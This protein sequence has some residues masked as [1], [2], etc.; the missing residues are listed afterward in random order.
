MELN[1]YMIIIT[2]LCIGITFLFSIILI[3]DELYNIGYFT[4]NY[5]YFYNYGTFMSKFN[6]VQTIECETNRFNVYN[7]ID[8]LYK[9]IFNKSYFNYLITIVIILITILFSLAYGVYFY[10]KFI[11]EVPELC[12]F[13]MET[14]LSLPKQILKCLC[15][16][17]HKIIP[18][19]TS[20]YLIVF[21]LLIII[22]LSY[23]FKTFVSINITPTTDNY[24]LSF[25][26]L[27][28]FVLLLFYYSFSLYNRKTDDK[29]KDLIIYF[30][31]TI[32]FISSPYIYN[33]IISNYN[34]NI[35]L[36]TSK[37]ISTMYD[38]Y[39]Q[40]PPI[41]PTPIQKPTHNRKDLLTLFKYDDKNTDPEYKIQK[42]IV[43]DYYKAIK[44]Y[45]NE[46][47]HYNERYNAYTSSSLTSTVFGDKADYLDIAINILGFNNK[48]HIYII[49]LVIIAYII[50]NMYTDDVSYVCFIYLLTILITITI[51]NSIL[52]YN[53]YL[54]K[55]IIYEPLAH[56]K[57]DITNANTALN[58]ELDAQ[59]GIGFYNKL[60]NNINTTSDINESSKNAKQIFAEIKTL[61]T[62]KNY[63]LDNVKKI[64]GYIND[65][66]QNE[67]INISSDNNIHKIDNINFYYK[68][69]SGVF[70]DNEKSI[71][72][73]LDNC[74]SSINTVSKNDIKIEPNK[75][76]IFNFNGSNINI[77]LKMTGYYRYVLYRIYQYKKL[78]D[79]FN[80]VFTSYVNTNHLQEY[81]KYFDELTTLYNSLDY[82]KESTNNN[83]SIIIQTINGN[84]DRLISLS[85]A[86]TD[87]KR[88][89]MY[90]DLIKQ[91]DGFKN[92]YI[93]DKINIDTLK[94]SYFID[95]KPVYF[96][97]EHYKITNDLIVINDTSFIQ[98]GVVDYNINDI[99]N[100]PKI[101][102]DINTSSTYNKLP[103][104][105]LDSNNNELYISISL[106]NNIDIYINYNIEPNEDINKYRLT[107]ENTPPEP[108][109]PEEKQADNYYKFILDVSKKY[110]IPFNFYKYNSNNTNKFKQIIISTLLNNIC[111]VEPLFTDENLLNKIARNKIKNYTPAVIASGSV[112][113]KDA[114]IT[115][116]ARKDL[117]IF[118]YHD[119]FNST[120]IDNLQKI[121]YTD[122]LSSSNKL[123]NIP[124]D[125]NIISYIILL[126]NAY[127]A[128][129]VDIK[130]DI[131]NK[132]NHLIYN[133]VIYFDSAITTTT[134]YLDKFVEGKILVNIKPEPSKNK[135]ITD[136]YIRLY[137]NNLFIINIIIKLYENLLL[138]IKSEIGKNE[139]RLCLPNKTSLSIIEST[140]YNIY[141]DTSKYNFSSVAGNL[142]NGALY[143]V[144][145]NSASP[146][147]DNESDGKSIKVINEHYIYFN[148][149]IKFLLDNLKLDNNS[150]TISAITANY[151]FYNKEEI[152]KE[153]IRKQLIINCD[154]NSKYNKLDTKQLSYFSTNAN[155]VSYNFPILMVIF[156]IVLGEPV[157]IKS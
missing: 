24:L 145:C 57:N 132:I 81:S 72:Y 75:L 95:S 3:I 14:D 21:I 93:K 146:I 90:K 91:I 104:K 73:L 38:I 149:I 133:N 105:I 151:N 103:N 119:Y 35:N 60:V 12:S 47:K 152:I 98:I 78:L 23:L 111:N 141:S 144:S 2:N 113:A 26:Y 15:D 153:P 77:I 22:P 97:I 154:Y 99:N 40:K 7:N 50:Y 11:I 123:L 128:A 121:D 155:N 136:E 41:K 156:I 1:Y 139:P 43:D 18:N 96:N 29:Y 140:I 117:K 59:T 125:K 5:T 92:D 137:N 122:T 8:F 108:I 30:F 116:E 80:S 27:C 88:K 100:K 143:T 33:Y 10:F 69:K 112:K 135:A 28:V 19:C 58:V 4:F 115:P 17:C 6:T 46:M 124:A 109:I 53:T 62:L 107:S 63:K 68:K 37:D 86:D 32:L 65:L 44:N 138:T 45:D 84:I 130:T 9:D 76:I 34:N 79:K 106:N 82:Y 55:Y 74:I 25:M 102:I 131:A 129:S 120:V 127:K 36:N 142:V 56:Y 51:M 67:F 20:N 101:D 64:N 157:F 49:I 31:F 39:K 66:S 147:A 118:K 48:M 94:K 150:S 83:H 87:T 71:K 134:Q 126:Y 85:I 61:L 89:N 114:V 42:T 148:N 70:S 52:Y 16:E 110:S 13:D 54:N